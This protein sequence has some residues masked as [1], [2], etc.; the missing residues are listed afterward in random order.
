MLKRDLL[1]MLLFGRP[2]PE[3]TVTRVAT[4]KDEKS[5]IV[6]KYVPQPNMKEL[7][8]LMIVIYIYICAHTHTHKH[9]LNLGEL[10][11]SLPPTFG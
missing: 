7:F 9:I 11:F 1:P 8:F 2:E 4:Y 6:Y 10:F 3:I 5:Y